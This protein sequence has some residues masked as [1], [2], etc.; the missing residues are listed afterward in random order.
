MTTSLLIG[1]VASISSCLA[2]VGG[3]VLS[4]S[5]TVSQDKVS[6]IR[7]M[8]FFMAEDYSDLHY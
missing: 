7:P 1:L 6:D 4:L 2:V 8:M 5:A 3:L